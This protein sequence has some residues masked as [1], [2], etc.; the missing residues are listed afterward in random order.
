MRKLILFILALAPPALAAAQAVSVSASPAPAAKTIVYDSGV[1]ASGAAITS[2]AV[3]VSSYTACTVYA[4]NSAGGSQ[5][6]VNFVG[7]LADGTTQLTNGNNPGGGGNAAVSTY[8]IFNIGVGISTY[9]VTNAGVYVLP[10]KIVFTMAAAGSA[11]GRLVVI[12]QRSA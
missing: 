8:A 2:P 9:G 7:Y 4:D 10:P 5:R 1:V 6:L 12:C 11:N 3:D